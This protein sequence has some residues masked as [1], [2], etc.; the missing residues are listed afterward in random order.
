MDK[1]TIFTQQ[2]SR[3][4]K[5]LTQIK[6]DGMEP[7][8]LKAVHAQ[9]IYQLHLT[10]GQ[11]FSELKKNCDSDAALISRALKE[12]CASE[13][14]IRHGDATKYNATYSLS[15][16]GEESC[17]YIRAV[18]KA[19]INQADAG[20]SDDD[21]DT[22]YSVLLRIISNFENMNIATIIKEVS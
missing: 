15:S 22:F 16:K 13:N 14:V 4:N 19:V 20:I 2:I 6:T 3:L 5:L 21:L 11:K 9:L 7:L 10:P 1:F 8:G 18:V 17:R 12:L